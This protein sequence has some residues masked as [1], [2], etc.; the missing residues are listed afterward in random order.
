VQN[1][2][3]LT[4]VYR[5]GNRIVIHDF[6]QPYYVTEMCFLEVDVE[7]QCI[8]IEN[9]FYSTNTFN[10]VNPNRDVFTSGASNTGGRKKILNFR[11]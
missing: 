1:S 10:L 4:I 11:L 9:L 2:L 3:N 8:I 7:Q 5:Y 6:T